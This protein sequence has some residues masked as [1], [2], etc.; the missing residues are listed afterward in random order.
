MPTTEAA[1]ARIE[2]L[3]MS[4]RSALFKIERIPSIFNRY[5]IVK[6]SQYSAD[7]HKM[8]RYNSLFAHLFPMNGLYLL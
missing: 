6:I 8:R 1:R 5:M 3:W 4:L 2:Y 7:Y